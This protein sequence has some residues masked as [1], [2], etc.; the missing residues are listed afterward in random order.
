MKQTDDSSQPLTPRDRSSARKA[1]RM[2][3]WSVAGASA[4]VLLVLGIA[5]STYV[6]RVS[7]V[8]KPPKPRGRHARPTP[9][10]GRIVDVAD[11]VPLMI[12]LGIIGVIFLGVIAWY[13]SRESTKPLER[14]L[15]IQ[16]A[17]VADASH[18]LR[19]P[20]T[21][22]SSRVQLAQ[23]RLSK[24]EDASSVLAEAKT[25]ADVL[26][27]VLTDLLLAA[28]TARDTTGSVAGRSGAKRVRVEADVEECAE[29]AVGLVSLKAQAQE[30]AVNTKIE[31]GLRVATSPTPLVRA[32]VIMLDNALAHSPPRSRV[33]VTATRRGDRA[34]IRVRDSGSGVRGISE[35]ELFQRFARSREGERRGFGLGLSLVK[36]LAQRFGGDISVEE[37]S[38]KGTTFLLVLPLAKA[39]SH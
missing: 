18:E 5:A 35:E 20:L 1:S 23:L 28:E 15:A 27:D 21:T 30:V 6:A 36:D 14:A 37:T 2:V 38:E 7:R 16:R 26:K 25:D 9:W 10:E 29:Q 34:L 12:L 33:A 39:P 19:T 13:V 4:L 8:Q 31:V 24:G 22:L 11:L 3:G 17:F 32:L